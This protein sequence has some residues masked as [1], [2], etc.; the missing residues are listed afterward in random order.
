MRPTKGEMRVTPDSA[1]AMAWQNENSRV[2]LQWMPC[3]SS[4]SLRRR[5]PEIYYQTFRQFKECA[6]YLAA[7]IPSQV[8]ASLMRIL[9]FSMPCSLYILINLV[10]FATL[11]T[12]SK[13]NLNAKINKTK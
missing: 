1:Q 2:R 6:T 12:L 13:D 11:P 8:E 5:M 3:F 10:A 9:S 4:S 7:W